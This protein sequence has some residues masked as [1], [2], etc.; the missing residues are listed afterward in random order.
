[1]VRYWTKNRL[2]FD[3]IIPAV[4]VLLVAFAFISPLLEGI[5]EAALMRGVYANDKLDFNV[6]TPSH[7]QID[8]LESLPFIFTV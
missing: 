2:I 1:M 3:L 6:S 4:T 7:A 5:G 8:D